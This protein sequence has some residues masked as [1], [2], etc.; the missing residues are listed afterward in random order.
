MMMI[1]A[2]MVAEGRQGI[3][4]VMNLARTMSN[5]IAI[6]CGGLNFH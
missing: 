5:G 3:L 1:C 4:A 2:E 6:A